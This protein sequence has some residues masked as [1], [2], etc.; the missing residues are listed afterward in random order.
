MKIRLFRPEDAAALAQI[1]HAAVHGVSA[2]DYSPEQ[3][4]AWSPEPAPAEVWQGRAGDGRFVFVAVDAADQPQGFIELER[5]GHIDCFYCHPD[6]AGTG[7]GLALYQQ[8]EAQAR[9]LGL[10]SLYVEASEAAKR[11]FTRQGFTDEGRREI[12]RRGVGLHN[13]RMTKAL[14]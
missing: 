7:V 3:C 14:S 13:Y 12:E 4:A 11:F 6:V 9:D 8:L 10:S 1:F 2:R 5:D